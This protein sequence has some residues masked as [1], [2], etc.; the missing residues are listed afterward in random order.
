MSLH[1]FKLL[2][3]SQASNPHT[4]VHRH[5]V[6]KPIIIADAAI[7]DAVATL[8]NVLVAIGLLLSQTLTQLRT[9]NVPTILFSLASNSMA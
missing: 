5:I 9:I 6:S 2:A 7:F 8:S 3:Y 1:R 4:L